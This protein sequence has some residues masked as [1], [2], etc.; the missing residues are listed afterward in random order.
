MLTSDIRH[1]GTGADGASADSEAAVQPPSAEY[2]K[3]AGKAAEEFE[4]LFIREM[5]GQMRKTTR[6]MAGSDSVFAQSINNDLMDFADVALA[7]QLARQR[8]FGIA[9]VILAQLLPDEK[10]N[11]NNAFKENAAEV[12]SLS[13]KAP[14]T[15]AGL[16]AF[17]T[18]LYPLNRN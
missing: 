16:A 6:E 1:P 2:R 7:G 12:A 13:Q 15:G 10:A 9:N 17:A 11:G 4:A 5:L 18:P 8:M 14:E 3:K